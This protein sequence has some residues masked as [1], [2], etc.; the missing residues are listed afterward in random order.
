[1]QEAPGQEWIQRS[2][3]RP[4]VGSVSVFPVAKTLLLSPTFA[5]AA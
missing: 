4:G 1:M 2:L 5:N 3:D